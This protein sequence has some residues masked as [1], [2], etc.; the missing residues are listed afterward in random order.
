VYRTS[1]VTSL[2]VDA[3]EPPLEIHRMYHVLSYFSKLSSLVTHPAHPFVVTPVHLDLYDHRGRSTRPL[4]IHTIELLETLG[5]DRPT[6]CRVHFSLRP[7]WTFVH[8]RVD[9]SLSLLSKAETSMIEFQQ[10][11]LEMQ[12]K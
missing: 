2:C 11:L 4:G 9:L 8:P 5:A 10:R 7:P 3:A 6:V 12:N 1:P